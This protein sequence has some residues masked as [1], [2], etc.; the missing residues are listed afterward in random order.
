M[1]SG[2]AESMKILFSNSEEISI[3]S[4]LLVGSKRM[5]SLMVSIALVGHS[6]Q[7][8]LA[9]TS[10]KEDRIS[11]EF[12][13]AFFLCFMASR[14]NLLFFHTMRLTKSQ[15]NEYTSASAASLEGSLSDEKTVLGV[16]GEVNGVELKLNLLPPFF[17]PPSIRNSGGV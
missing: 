6:S 13:F 12:N 17:F 3:K 16:E 1:L 2:I 4:F 14:K 7:C 5:H 9:L 8:F 11:S 10:T 15:P